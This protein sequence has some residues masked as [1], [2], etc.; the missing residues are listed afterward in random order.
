MMLDMPLDSGVRVIQPCVACWREPNAMSRLLRV[1]WLSAGR[2]SI[3]EKALGPSMG[4]RQPR[5]VTGETAS[6]RAGTW[7]LRG[8]RQK[9]PTARG[10]PEPKQS[11]PRAPPPAATGHLPPGVL[12]H[13]EPGA[14][15]GPPALLREESGATGTFMAAVPRP[16]AGRLCASAAETLG[17]QL[18]QARA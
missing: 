2:H 13:G 6:Q 11:S 9:L 14:D 12:H 7:G 3:P 18:L 8:P 10:A 5:E 15:V 16:V 1:S 4:P 17:P